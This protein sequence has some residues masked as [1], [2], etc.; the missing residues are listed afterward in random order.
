MHAMNTELAVQYYDGKA[1]AIYRSMS[2]S[3]WAYPEGCTPYYP[4]IGSKISASVFNDNA[5][6]NP[7]YKEFVLY[8]TS[9][10]ATRLPLTNR[11]SSS[12]D[13]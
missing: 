12:T 7:D 6:V 11:K 8:K 2:K 10:P 4:Y 1:E 5:V 9:K 13:F 3:S